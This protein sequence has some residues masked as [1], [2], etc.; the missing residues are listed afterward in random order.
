VIGT[1]AGVRGR[2]SPALAESH[3]I[4]ERVTRIER[5]RS[6]GSNIPNPEFLFG[7][8]V[9]EDGVNSYKPEAEYDWAKGGCAGGKS[10]PEFLIGF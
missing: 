7:F 6:L 5:V 10:H 1:G 4:A 2:N 8:R 3:P 9:C